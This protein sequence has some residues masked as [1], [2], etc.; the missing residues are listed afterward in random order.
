PPE[1]CT[2]FG[3]EKWPYD[4][5]T[6]GD[7]HH[8]RGEF[9]DAIA[10]YR[11]VLTMDPGLKEEVI[12]SLVNAYVQ[13]AFRIA[14]QDK[15]EPERIDAAITAIDNGIGLDDRGVEAHLTRGLLLGH[16]RRGEEAEAVFAKAFQMATPTHLAYIFRGRARELLRN[17]TAAMQDYETV[18]KWPA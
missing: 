10:A 4:Q 3:N 7:R 12:P 17:T 14:W 16:L 8:N 5:F 11:R 13:R 1:W 9:D 6:R 2:Q 18:V 15:P